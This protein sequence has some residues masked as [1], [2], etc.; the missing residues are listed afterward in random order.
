[1]VNEGQMC[2]GTVVVDGGGGGGIIVDFDDEE[3][4]QGRVYTWMEVVPP[5]SSL[6]SPAQNVL[7]LAYK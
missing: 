1:M 5:H 6:L 3:A 7:Q 2:D 4:L